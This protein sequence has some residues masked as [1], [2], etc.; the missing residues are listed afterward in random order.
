MGG[1]PELAFVSLRTLRRN[2]IPQTGIS[3]PTPRPHIGTHPSH[4]AIPIN[5][6][7]HFGREDAIDGILASERSV[8]MLPEQ[9][10]IGPLSL[11]ARA[12]NDVTG[13]LRPQ[14]LCFAYIEALTTTGQE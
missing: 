5:A 2:D 12:A 4:F 11:V 10:C 6:K 7:G 14:L 9:L 8:P 1:V 13:Q 3:Q